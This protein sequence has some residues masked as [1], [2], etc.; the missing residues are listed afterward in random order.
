M[1]TRRLLAL[2]LALL[3]LALLGAGYF[4]AAPRVQAVQPAPAAG[5]I[6]AYARLE[7]TFSRPM[8]SET[9]AANL[10]IDPPGRAPP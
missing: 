1:N 8:A 7:L 9:V 5:P 4:R 3:L 10:Q 2:L 6:P